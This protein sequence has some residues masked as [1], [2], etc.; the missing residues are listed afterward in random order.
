MDDPA[1]L[2]DVREPWEFEIARIDGAKLMPLGEIHE[3]AASLNRDLSYVLMCHH[4]VRSAW[5]CQ[6]LRSLG[7]TDVTNLDGGIDAWALFVDPEMR[8]Y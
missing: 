5:A 6:V 1:V 7:F 8:R 3:W 4:G 2:I